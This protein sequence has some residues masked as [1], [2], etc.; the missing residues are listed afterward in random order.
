MGYNNRLFWIRDR[1]FGMRDPGRVIIIDYFQG[2]GFPDPGG[3]KL[4]I[5]RIRDQTDYYAIQK[6]PNI[7]LNHKRRLFLETG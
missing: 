6:I 7:P 2:S 5:F 3:A 1:G 4:I